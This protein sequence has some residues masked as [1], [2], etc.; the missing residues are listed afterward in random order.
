MR[1]GVLISPMCHDTFLFLYYIRKELNRRGMSHVNF[2]QMKM[3]NVE[4][5]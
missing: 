3:M 2:N 5:Q 4:V 1:L